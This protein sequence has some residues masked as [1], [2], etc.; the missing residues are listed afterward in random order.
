VLLSAL[1]LAGV[2]GS[3]PTTAGDLDPAFGSGGRV[4]FTP[5]NGS[6]ASGA[7][8]Q[9]D[10]KIVLAGTVTNAPPPPPLPPRG[11]SDESPD[12][13]AVRMAANGA[14]DESFGSGGFAQIPIDLGNSNSDFANAV[15]PAPNG[16]LVLGGY[17]T[18]VVGGSDS[19]IVRLT[20]AGAPDPSFAGDGIQTV[21]IGA[22]QSDLVYGVAVQPD[23]KVVA[24]G[25]DSSGLAV[26]RIDTDGSLDPTFGEGG[27][28]DTPIGEPAGRDEARAVAV[29]GDGKIVVAGVSDAEWP[30]IGKVAVARY[31]PTG[32]LD[33]A[34]GTGGIVLTAG[35]PGERAAAYTLA[36]QPD[37]RI[38]VGGDVF[39]WGSSGRSIIARYLP[40]GALD[41]SFGDGGIV[42]TGDDTDGL[43][44]SLAVDA[45]GK[46]VA[47]GYAPIGGSAHFAL[48]RFHSDGSPD[49]SF[50]SGG[51]Q[52]YDVGGIS[53]AL[54]I[55]GGARRAVAAGS[56]LVDGYPHVAAI[57][58]QLGPLGPPPPPPV[59]PP[60]PPP[61]PPPPPPGPPPVPPPP[62]V[63]PP[64]PPPP[65]AE[66][67]PPPAVRCV[68]PRV[69]HLRLARARS[70]IRR[71][72]C[73]VGGVRS[74]RSTRFR[75]IVLRQ[76]PG[77]GRRL[78]RGTRVNLVVGRR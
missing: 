27:I 62:P 30:Y 63:G 14:L 15:A 51:T 48:A 40:T 72:H 29:T 78:A 39:P 74:I 19:V 37:G 57:G 4:L 38:V 11:P 77:A 6:W 1:V 52:T 8:L 45:D 25:W 53:Y 59:P 70:K 13:L 3:A 41:A 42:F 55:D 56:S 67:P 71:A 20:S 76:S 34:F 36:L 9:P 33:P 32:Q 17:A 46:L 50:G 16:T 75:G 12:F 31:L 66:P 44:L 60:P 58:V 69:V 21:D 24:A 68:V 2:G 73:R 5:G 43:V 10:G 22:G 35:P 47:A 7:A 64:P 65:P 23:G 26:F 61:V 28:V 18:T 54:L 49:G